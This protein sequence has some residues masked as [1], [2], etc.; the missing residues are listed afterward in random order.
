MPIWLLCSRPP[1][2]CSG[3]FRQ[4]NKQNGLRRT[5]QYRPRHPA[6]RPPGFGWTVFSPRCFSSA[7]VSPFW[8]EG[9]PAKIDDRTRSGTLNPHLSTADRKK[10]GTNLVQ[11]TSTE[12]PSLGSPVPRFDNSRLARGPPEF[13]S[14]S[15]RRPVKG[16]GGP[17]TFR[18]VSRE[19][20]DCVKGRWDDGP[21]A[22]AKW[23]ITNWYAK[24]GCKSSSAG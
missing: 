6:T 3:N 22:S 16:R 1:P 4:K 15:S 21:D 20:V 5:P 8:G 17:L 18:D 12:G 10:K 11:P 9:S 24:D 19:V 13:A 2:P 14:S 7:L 23:V